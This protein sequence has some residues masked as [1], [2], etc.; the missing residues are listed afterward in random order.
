M[1]EPARGGVQRIPRPTGWLPGI[2]APWLRAGV[3]PSLPLAAVRRRLADLPPPRPAAESVIDFPIRRRASAV[4]AALFEADGEARVILTK[5]PET[6]P[7]H[8]GEIAF[9]GGKLE[10]GV[11]ADLR[12]TALREAREEID[13]DPA[14]V[15]IVAELD[16]LGTVGSRFMISPFVGLLDRVPELHPNPHEVVRVFDVALVELLAPGVHHAERWK[17]PMIDHEVHFFELPGETVWGATARILFGFLAF[18]TADG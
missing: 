10:E 4:L 18:L 11:D 17:T 7:S 8:Q 9:P 14:A 6:M 3:T 2:E 12:A 16:G 15:E 13:L 1:A 5:R